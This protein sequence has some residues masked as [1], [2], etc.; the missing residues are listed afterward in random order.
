MEDC[1]MQSPRN[2]RS[3]FYRCIQ[4]CE[5]YHPS[6]TY[7]VHGY[8]IPNC[9]HQAVDEELVLFRR[10]LF[11]RIPY[12][13]VATLHEP[14]FKVYGVRDVGICRE[15]VCGQGKRFEGRVKVG[16]AVLGEETDKIQATERVS[17][18]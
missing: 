17:A 12:F 8:N 18:G 15:R 10:C 4:S 13:A 1:R 2:L 6:R 5:Q 16:D 11:S 7:S 9:A 3:H 14:L